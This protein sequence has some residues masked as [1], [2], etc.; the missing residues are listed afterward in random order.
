MAGAWEVLG[1][2][3][4]RAAYDLERGHV[5]RGGLPEDWL[6]D[7]ATA[8]DRAER[9]VREGVLPHLA[10]RLRGQGLE[11]AVTLLADLDDLRTPRNL[12]PAGPWPRRRLAR[13]LDTIEVSV[14]LQPSRDF[15]RN[16]RTRKGIGI[17]IHPWA[18]FHGGVRDPLLLDDVLIQVLLSRFALAL[19]A[20]RVPSPADGDWTEARRWARSIDDQTVSDARRRWTIRLVVLGLL[21]LMFTAGHRG[22]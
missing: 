16:V 1:D 3:E 21:G 11:L 15:S 12:Q 14:S 4:K 7:F 13:Q 9:W 17:L 5:G 22:W 8:L 2:P 18:L 6:E 19:G 20:W 10:G